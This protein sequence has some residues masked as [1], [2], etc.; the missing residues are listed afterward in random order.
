MARS[1]DVPQSDVLRRIRW[2]E[3][4]N[5][6]PREIFTDADLFRLEMDVF[7]GPVWIL[8][9]HESEVTQC[10]RTSSS[11]RSSRGRVHQCPHCE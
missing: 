1:I 9:G 5:K 11:T 10:C 2:P 4:D 7:T 8:V 3:V 6:I